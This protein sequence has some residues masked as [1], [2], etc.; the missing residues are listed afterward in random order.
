MGTQSTVLITGG[1]RGIGLALT[2]QLSQRGERVIVAC[3]QGSDELNALVNDESRSVQLIENLDVR[4]PQTL[5]QALKDLGVTKLDLL[6]NNA[7]LLVRDSLTD[8]D[9]T[10]IQAQFDINTLG[11]LKVTEACLPFLAEGS[12]V[13]NVSSRMGSV[14]DNTSGGMYGYRI[15]KAALNMASMSLAKDLAPQGIAVIILHPGYVRT[16][17]TGHNGLIDTDESAQG[18]IKLIDELSLE[19]SGQFWHTNGE[20]LPW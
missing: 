12:K 11:P 4:S 9:Y 8:L 19:T 14:T 6:I 1:N 13:A 15:S 3:R 17:M 20:A 10:T 7:G 16:G 18:L 5:G 2:Q